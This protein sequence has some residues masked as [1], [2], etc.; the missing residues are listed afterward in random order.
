[1][2]RRGDLRTYV[3][4]KYDIHEKQDPH[5]AMIGVA[6]K[7]LEARIEMDEID[8]MLP[9]ESLLLSDPATKYLYPLAKGRPNKSHFP[10]LLNHSANENVQE[11]SHDNE[12]EDELQF[13]VDN[14]DIDGMKKCYTE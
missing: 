1:M 6:K 2:Y 5:G 9:A 8:E 7:A 12:D 11:F 3:T 10:S 13:Q 14:V 4:D